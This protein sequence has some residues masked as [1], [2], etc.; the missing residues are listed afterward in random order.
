MDLCES[1]PRSIVE[2]PADSSAPPGFG[3]VCRDCT[4]V[5]AAACSAHERLG[6]FFAERSEAFTHSSSSSRQHRG[7]AEADALL[8]NHRTFFQLCGRASCRHA[9]TLG[10]ASSLPNS[11]RLNTP[12]KSQLQRLRLDI[13]F[14]V[15]VTPQR[16]SSCACGAPASL[17]VYQAQPLD[18]RWWNP[19]TDPWKQDIK[20][21]GNASNVKVVLHRMQALHTKWGP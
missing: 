21:M 18:L 8:A 11:W 4:T 19:F 17:V 2:P 20:A 6:A 15:E 5:F 9:P 10:G 3:F 12:A 16:Q 7:A 1:V 13:R 14:H